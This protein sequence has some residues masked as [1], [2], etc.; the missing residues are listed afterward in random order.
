MK[1]Y[2][3]FFK[4]IFSAQGLADGLSSHT[5]HLMFKVLL[6]HHLIR[7]LFPS[8]QSGLNIP[9]ICSHK[10]FF[11]SIITHRL[12]HKQIIFYFFGTSHGMWHLFPDQESNLYLLPWKPLNCQQSPCKLLFIISFFPLIELKDLKPTNVLFTFYPVPDAVVVPDTQS[13]LSIAEMNEQMNSYAMNS[14]HL[15]DNDFGECCSL[16]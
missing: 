15:K 6:G 8:P 5:V 11:E 12:L 13:L 4:F 7:K 2:L 10:P 3:A 16:S 14:V 9:P 1:I